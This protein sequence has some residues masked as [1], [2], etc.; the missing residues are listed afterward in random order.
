MSHLFPNL[1]TNILTIPLLSI[2]MI[3]TLK[4]DMNMLTTKFG[5]SSIGDENKT[6]AESKMEIVPEIEQES[7]K[8]RIGCDQNQQSSSRTRLAD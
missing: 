8:V 3:T 5:N 4:S 2:N 1:C 7:A 6:E